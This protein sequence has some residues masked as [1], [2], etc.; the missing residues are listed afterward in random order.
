MRDVWK[1]PIINAM[2]VER[3]GYPTQKPLKLLE[4]IINA[5]TSEDAIILD[6]FCGCA[7]TCVASEKLN[8]KW[9]GI[10]ISKKAYDLVT[11]RLLDQEKIEKQ[12][13]FSRT[14]KVQKREVYL[15]TDI[16]KREDEEKI[17]PYNHPENKEYLYGKQKGYCKGCDGNHVFQ[18]RHLE[19]DHII[20]RSKG[21]SNDITNLQLLCNSCNRIKGDGTM[22]ELKAKLKKEG[23]I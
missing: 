7:T 10:D 12:V 11:K 4:R 20:P 15:R 22:S 16:P 2:A 17:K 18:Y 19:I 21:G 1:I 3:V 6:P 13:I 9:I 14:G 5:S 23:L 8:R